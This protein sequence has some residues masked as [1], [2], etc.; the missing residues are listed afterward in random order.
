MPSSRTLTKS[1]LTGAKVLIN[2][3]YMDQ[4]AAAK[5]LAEARNFYS[6]SYK[7]PEPVA[8]VKSAGMPKEQKRKNKKRKKRP[9][10]PPSDF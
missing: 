9:L 5:A 6:Q 2:G 8:T 7:T 3:Q 1:E 10:E 4:K